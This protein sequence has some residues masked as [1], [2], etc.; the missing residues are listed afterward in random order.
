M[1]Y[2]P[3]ITNPFKGAVL[4]NSFFNFKSSGN[5]SLPPL[6][7][8]LGVLKSSNASSGKLPYLSVFPSLSYTF[9]ISLS[10]SC[11]HLSVSPVSCRDPDRYTW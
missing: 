10:F 8:P 4:Q 6:P 9:I 11:S 1:D 3:D 2:V 5:G 7:L